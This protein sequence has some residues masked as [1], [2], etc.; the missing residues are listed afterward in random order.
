MS[1]TKTQA[2]SVWTTANV[3]QLLKNHRKT[4]VIPDAH[5]FFNRKIGRRKAGLVFGYTKEELLEFLKCEQDILYFAN[6]FCKI[7][8]KFGRKLI[9][10]AGGLRPYQEKLLKQFQNNQYNIVLASRQIGKSIT[11]AIY[12]CWY[13][14]FNDDANI[15]LLSATGGK[16][17]DLLTKIK[18]IQDALPFYMQKGLV[19][20]STQKRMYENGCTLISENTTENAGV[21]GTY[22]FVY[23]DEM[24]LLDDEMQEKIFTGLF[25]TM[26][27]F[28]EKAKF[29][30][31]STP[32][33]RN[34]KFYK[35]WAGATAEKNS[36]RYNGFA[37]AKVYWYEN[38]SNDEKWAKKER[39]LMGE[40]GFAREYDLSFDADEQLLMT[41]MIK[42]LVSKNSTQYVET[43]KDFVKLRPDYQI[44]WLADPIRRFHISVDL[45]S[46]K[47]GKNDFTVFNIFEIVKKEDTSLKRLEFIEDEADFYKQKQ[48]GII[49]S[50]SLDI[51]Y[52]SRLLYET[53]VD[54]FIPE[55]V[56]ITVETNHKGGEFINNIFTYLGN[57][58][59]LKELRD[60]IIVQY[61]LHL[62]FEKE[63]PKFDEGIYQTA[64]SKKTTTDLFNTA[65]E[66][67]DLEISEE[68]TVEEGLS[69]GKDKKGNYKGLGE[70]DDCFMT[71]L[72]AMP[73]KKTDH[74]YDFI[75]DL[76]EMLYPE[77]R[78]VM[79]NLLG[80]HEEG[81][82]DDIYD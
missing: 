8:S 23:W 73:F 82:E 37:Y 47:D 11:V 68:T 15:L 5:P 27:S 30:I 35:L 44:E 32:R 21:S 29:M 7:M 49:R 3:E 53:I 46:G 80:K 71:V 25:P 13:I 52:T 20:N 22:E 38:P 64:K 63:K 72:N 76:Y 54:C 14:L 59:E 42:R 40:S 57:K 58:N 43:E 50:N 12:V 31:T 69:F 70:H 16:A 61:P 55:H 65:M 1:A 45:A 34:N 51:S 17:K 39:L 78:L 10:E 28:G 74:F 26:S 36:G 9:K 41:D 6:N 2:T 56:R 77:E 33:G 62:D 18:E 66:R 67:D 48:V 19:Y 75:N 60:D 4:G 79:D 81:D 24:A